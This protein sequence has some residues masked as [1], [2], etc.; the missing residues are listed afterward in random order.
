MFILEVLCFLEVD[1]NYLQTRLCK[2]K[3]SKLTNRGSCLWILVHNTHIH[4]SF[5]TVYSYI[6]D[7]SS[8]RKILQ[9]VKMAEIQASLQSPLFSH[10]TEDGDCCCHSD[11]ICAS[12]VTLHFPLF[13]V[14][15]LC[16]GPYISSPSLINQDTWRFAYVTWYFCKH[17]FSAKYTEYFTH[18]VTC[19]GLKV[20][21]KE[22]SCARLF[23]CF[24]WT[25]LLNISVSEHLDLLCRCHVWSLKQAVIKEVCVDVHDHRNQNSPSHKSCS[26]IIGSLFYSAEL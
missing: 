19:P 21:R 13:N 7:I 20:N 9:L 12:P 18:F 24:V 3:T 17:Y 10:Q 15:K 5:Y 11:L 4:N 8:S 16:S 22:R 25:T 6:S 23:D 14:L 1:M 2:L 26:S